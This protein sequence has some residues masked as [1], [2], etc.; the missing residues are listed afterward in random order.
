LYL[1]QEICP[2][3]VDL[4]GVEL[5]APH[6]YDA[7][8]HTLAVIDGLETLLRILAVEFQGSDAGDLVLAEISLKLGRY[9]SA[10]HEYL[11]TKYRTGRQMDQ[12]LYLAAL[13]HDV[14][15][16]PKFNVELQGLH[17]SEIG[18]QILEARSRTLRLSNAEIKWLKKV[19]RMHSVPAE[20]EQQ[21]DATE[22]DAYRFFRQSGSS[23]I[24]ILLLS[25]ADL[26]GRYSP[27][28]P[29]EGISS[30]VEV[31]RSL[32]EVRFERSESLF[33]PRVID[34]N[35]LIQAGIVRPGPI[36]AIILEQIREA[37]V[38]GEVQTREEALS[39]AKDIVMKMNE[40][41]E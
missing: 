31:L 13:Y 11:K 17:H 30:R 39:F 27:L 5:P 33:P 41:E 40:I 6:A 16:A 4:K 3:V 14:G 34:G 10:F 25:L 21:G 9:R 1:F 38:V 7:F 28:P 26:F 23:G 24:G 29:A 37:Q 36:Y 20:L 35:D 15:K 32:L 2:E 18:E 12:L 8:E 19:V 22:L